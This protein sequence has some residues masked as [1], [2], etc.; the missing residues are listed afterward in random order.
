M[1]LR[2]SQSDLYPA[3]SIQYVVG[4][5]CF[6][7]AV[8]L[9]LR[10]FSSVVEVRGFRIQGSFDPQSELQTSLGGVHTKTL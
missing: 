7:D 6:S 2:G 3:E 9:S 5:H 1:E 4:M 8:E 10:S